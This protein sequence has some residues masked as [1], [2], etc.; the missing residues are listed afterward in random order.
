MRAQ[1]EAQPAAAAIHHLSKARDGPRDYAKWSG[2]NVSLGSAVAPAGAWPA[3][4]VGIAQPA[5]RR[6]RGRTSAPRETVRP[7]ARA[8][9]V[10][11]T[12]RDATHIRIECRVAHGEMNRAHKSRGT[13]ALPEGISVFLK[14]R[15]APAF[16]G[17][18]FPITQKY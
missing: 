8:L 18:I 3:Q 10:V 15:A 1:H 14:K 17:I 9:G 16:Q 11:R 6:A 2:S 13:S 12:G 7:S 4:R 5:M